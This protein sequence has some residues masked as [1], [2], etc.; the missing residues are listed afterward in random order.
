MSIQGGEQFRSC[1]CDCHWY[2]N[3]K[4]CSGMGFQC[5]DNVGRLGRP[6]TYCNACNTLVDY[7]ETHK[8]VCI[9]PE[10]K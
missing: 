6:I 4:G 5:C 3:T 7:F 8:H 9:K 10:P 1:D 2:E